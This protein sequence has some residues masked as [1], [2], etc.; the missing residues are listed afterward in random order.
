MVQGQQ[1]RLTSCD[2][3]CSDSTGS[4]ALEQPVQEEDKG[5]LGRGRRWTRARGLKDTVCLGSYRND[6]G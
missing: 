4:R 2:G 5:V 6:L 1:L 3:S